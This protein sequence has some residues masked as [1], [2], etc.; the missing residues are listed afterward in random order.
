LVAVV[1]NTR[2]FDQPLI[3]PLRMLLAQIL[4]VVLCALQPEG[5]LGFGFAAFIQCRVVGV[6]VLGA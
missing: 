3:Q 1:P 2:H 6:S 5:T 4:K